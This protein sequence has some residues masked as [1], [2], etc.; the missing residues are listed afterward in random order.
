M[1]DPNSIK[2]A[3][4][5]NTHWLWLPAGSIFSRCCRLL[6]LLRVLGFVAD[7]QL[8]GQ[9]SRCGNRKAFNSC[10]AFPALQRNMP[11][12]QHLLH[13]IPCLRKI[14]SELLLSWAGHHHSTLPCPIQQQQLLTGQALGPSLRPCHNS[15][16]PSHGQ[17]CLTGEEMACTLLPI[18]DSACI[19]GFQT[20]NS[21]NL[22]SS[23]TCGLMSLHNPCH[24]GHPRC[25]TRV[26]RRL[27]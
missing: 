20:N 12:P 17:H 21:L 25:I 24:P 5:T 4:A 16:P 27:P 6:E 7:A 14:P 2:P 19:Q 3:P 11:H 9:Q 23:S 26:L 1:D 10:C 18:L 13:I 22:S 8:T 15:T